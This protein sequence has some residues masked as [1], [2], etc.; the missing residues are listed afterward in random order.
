MTDDK[1]NSGTGSTPTPDKPSVPQFP[2]GRV[3]LSDVPEIPSFPVDRI[4][5][6]EK[7]GDISKNDD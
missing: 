1:D 5:K 7:A 4:E 2:T 6:G 3:E